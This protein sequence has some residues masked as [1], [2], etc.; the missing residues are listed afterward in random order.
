MYLNWDIEDYYKKCVKGGCD[1][2]RI[3]FPNPHFGSFSEPL[4]VVDVKGRIIL[5]YLPD[6]LSEKD[7]VGACLQ[8]RNVINI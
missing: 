4:T 3:R 5:W 2:K 1:K 7:E 8:Y 6:L